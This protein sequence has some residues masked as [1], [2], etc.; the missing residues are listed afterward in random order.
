[1]ISHSRVNDVACEVPLS[2]AWRPGDRIRGD[3]IV[4]G[5]FIRK[6]VDRSTLLLSAKAWDPQNDMPPDPEKP[7]TRRSRLHDADVR[8]LALASP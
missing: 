2:A 5:T 4:P 6:I 8:A 1:M 7:L 3:W